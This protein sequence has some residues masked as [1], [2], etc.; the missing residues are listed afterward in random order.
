M[1]HYKTREEWLLAAV[2]AITP[3]FAEGTIEML[4]IDNWEGD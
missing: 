1:H 4:Q 3:L 2:E